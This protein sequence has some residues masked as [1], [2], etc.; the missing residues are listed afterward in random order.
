ML[1]RLPQNTNRQQHNHGFT[2]V[3]L[4]VV[5]VVIGILAAITIVSYTGVSQRAV[6]SSLQSD[7]TSNATKLKSYYILYGAYPTALDTN[8]CP[9]AP[10]IDANFCLKSSSSATLSYSSV[11]PPTFH[12]TDTNSSSSY[13]ITDSTPPTL[14]TTTNGSTVGSA[15]P[16]GFIP[17]PGSGTYGT[18]DFCVMKYAASHSDATSGA[19]GTST[20]PISAPSVQEWI[21]VSQ[22]TSIADAPNVANCPS[23]HLIT[24][25]EFLTIAQNVLSVP[26]NWNTGTVGSGYIYSGHNDGAPNNA[27][28]ADPSDSNGYAGETNT[29]GNQRRTL[30]LSNGQV[31]WDLAGNVHEWTSGTST[32]GVPGI[33]GAGS[34]WREWTAITNPGSLSPNPFPATT[35]ISGAINWNSSNGIGGILSNADA[36]T[37]FGF[38]R[39][40]YYS[41]TGYAGALSFII[42][43]SPSGT[44]AFVGFRVS[45]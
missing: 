12:L 34:S 2:I 16:S 28:V 5:I 26:G 19:Q 30:T 43:N 41:S 21:S 25:A 31:I 10:T 20:T 35:G 44:Y 4:L 45:R 11:A 13:A 3:E 23:C 39:G 9:T 24:E 32:T 6:I 42:N 8:N 17:V 40:G 15:C 27:L 36:S 1:Q 38:V 14:A 7:L 33:T 37:L 22:T 18:N 29:G